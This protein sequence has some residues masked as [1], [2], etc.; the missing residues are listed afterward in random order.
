M[1]WIGRLVESRIWSREG[2]WPQDIVRLTTEIRQAG[3]SLGPAGL[4]AKNERD[5][6][7]V[8][9]KDLLRS[10]DSIYILSHMAQRAMFDRGPSR[11]W[12]ATH[13]L[14]ALV[15]YTVGL[16]GAISEGGG[17]STEPPAEKIQQAFDLVADISALD[18]FLVKYSLDPSQPLII[19]RTQN[20]LRM[21]KL[22]DRYQGYL[23]HLSIIVEKTFHRIQNHVTSELG[24]NPATLPDICFAIVD[25]LQERMDAFDPA[26]RQALLRAKAQGHDAFQEATMVFLENHNKWV[27]KL[28]NISVQEL[29][30]ALE[31]PEDLVRRALGDLALTRGSQ[32]EFMLPT[33]D[34]PARLYSILPMGN[35]QFFIWSPG[36]LLQESH[37]WFDDLL[38]KRKLGTL[39]ARYLKARDDATEE[40]T[41]ES[42]KKIFGPER[43]FGNAYY[44]ADGRP[45]V[46][47]VVKVPRDAL[48]V[49]CKA[50]SL[51]P[52]G[53]R[54][55]PKRISTKFDELVTKPSKQ[56]A[57]FAG[58]LCKGSTI[59]NSN[60]QELSFTVD[61]QSILP[62]IV[63]TYE[64]VDPLA[65]SAP[66]LSTQGDK[67]RAWVLSLAD[68]LVVVDLLPSPSA[69]WYYAITRWQQSQEQRLHVPSE[70][71]ILGLFF[72]S[73][74][75]FT[76]LTE[77]LKSK[78]RIDVGPSGQE[79]NN[80]YTGSRVA[81]AGNRQKPAI[82]IPPLVLN[83][84][85]RML[86]TSSDRWKAAVTAV[87]L[88]PN[89]TWARLR[90]VQRKFRSVKPPRRARIKTANPSLAI[91]IDHGQDGK[92]RLD[93]DF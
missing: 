48:I 12:Y 39:R 66:L 75:L 2:E 6:R 85:D 3:T 77:H 9:L 46:D 93:V 43:V 71:D 65:S 18:W 89:K 45:D 86:E 40:L 59:F 55:A 47:C 35:D 44:Y 90:S 5:K 52:S 22:L 73:A 74:D 82:S 42:L 84:L 76:S 28:F 49:E 41:V 20:M 91:W 25:I 10:Y 34:N 8:A 30:S 14:H 81:P 23:T 32:S 1:G 54:G 88:E 63:V 64:R 38:Q 36:S 79:I 68:L 26:T 37:A 11:D 29:T 80:Y 87:M 58:H 70:I 60:G 51:T 56:A 62:R 61:E 33:Q 31:W 24:W 4:R 67:E 7:A 69:F 16:A 15:E 27:R 83:A 50:H 92:F 21:E 13:G 78:E 72:S 17:N 19:S 53:R 57:R